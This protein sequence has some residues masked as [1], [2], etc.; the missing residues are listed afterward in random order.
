VD[1]FLGLSTWHQWLRLFDLAHIMVVRRSGRTLNPGDMSD[2]LMA[3]WQQ[4]K[5]S[6]FP[7]TPAGSIVEFAMTPVDISA[8][9]IRELL[10]RR[11]SV[12]G[13]VPYSVLNYILQHHL[14]EQPNPTP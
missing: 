9:E 1:A 5:V 14:Y 8:T 6:K 3:Q 7:E 4:R 13:M 11:Q 10:Y 12:E 2:E